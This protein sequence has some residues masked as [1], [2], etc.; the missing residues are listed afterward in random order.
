VKIYLASTS[1]RRKSLLK[2]AGIPFLV[3]RPPHK[4]D[5]NLKA[6]PSR[7]VRIHAAAKAASCVNQIKN[8]FVLSAD[9][10]V[11]LKGKIFGKPRNMKEAHRMLARL[12]GCWQSVYTGVA[13]FKVRHGRAVKEIVFYEKTKI[14]LKKMDSAEIFRYFK[15]V[16]PLDKAG[17]CSIQSSRG[18]LLEKISGSFSNAVGLPVETLVKILKKER[19]KK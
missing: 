10:V 5:E 16:N 3:I 4:E 17:A 13:I 19:S 11:A 1:P 7:L 14:L 8:G 9:T 18:G 12:Q 15:K 6:S 2:K